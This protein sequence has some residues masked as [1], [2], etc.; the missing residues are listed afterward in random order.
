MVTIILP[1]IYKAFSTYLIFFLVKVLAANRFKWSQTWSLIYFK[2]CF[3]GDLCDVCE[4]LR[5]VGDPEHYVG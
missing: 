2:L 4:V 1:F 5:D 3:F